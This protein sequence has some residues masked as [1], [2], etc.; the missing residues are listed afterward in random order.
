STRL[1]AFV[2]WDIQE[3][4]ADGVWKS[5]DT[6][7]NDVFG[8]PV[9]VWVASNGEGWALT[10]GAKILH[11]PAGFTTW[12]LVGPIAGMPSNT[13]GFV[14][15]TAGQI[16][17]SEAG[18]T[19]RKDL[20]AVDVGADGTVIMADASQPDR[21][22]GGDVLFYTDGVLAPY[23]GNGFG[24]PSIPSGITIIDANNT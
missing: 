5:T 16:E 4:G 17:G 11:L 20:L 7:A 14:T 21:S 13:A 1:F 22:S 19:V 9:D 10:S 24:P 15:R 23:S 3:L 12:E 2:D 8:P 18:P 6:K